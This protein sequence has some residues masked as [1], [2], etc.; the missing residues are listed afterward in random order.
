MIIINADKMNFTDA[1]IKDA[2]DENSTE[3]KHKKLT[4]CG[5]PIYG[6]ENPLVRY[7]HYLHECLDIPFQQP[8]HDAVNDIL[9]SKC[10][11]KLIWIL[12]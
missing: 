4:E 12:A 3:K 9:L 6:D 10:G 5:I 7:C 8:N 1:L 11:A 2:F